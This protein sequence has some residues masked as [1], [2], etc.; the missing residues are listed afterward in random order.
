[1]A[2]LAADTHEHLIGTP[3]KPAADV[4]QLLR[5]HRQGPE[6]ASPGRPR[7]RKPV[8]GAA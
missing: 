7:K 1:M 5:A 8:A 6:A 2:G 3:P 4:R